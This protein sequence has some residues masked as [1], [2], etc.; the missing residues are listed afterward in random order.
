[1]RAGLAFLLAAAGTCAGIC[2]AAAADQASPAQAGCHAEGAF[3]IRFGDKPPAFLKPAERS[4][5]NV[6]YVYKP[7]RP[8]PHFDQYR[9][10][11]DAAGTRIY[12]VQAFRRMPPAQGPLTRA[13]KEEAKQRAVQVLREHAASQ[14]LDLDADYVRTE[15]DPQVW[16][17]RT[18][19]V[20][21]ALHGDSP[22]SAWMSCS[23]LPLED[24]ALKR[25]SPAAAS[26]P[27]SGAASAGAPAS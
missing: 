14:G 7:P 25:A 20:A 8:S 26:A 1:M 12:Q 23:H 11:A 19:D 10:F 17:R 6:Q 5:S 24:E 21:A 3:G 13:A 18:G 16:T 15:Q 22:W 9:V 2:P 27:T 4:A